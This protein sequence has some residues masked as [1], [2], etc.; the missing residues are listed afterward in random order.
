MRSADGVD[1]E[2]HTSNVEPDSG[3]KLLPE[4]FTLIF[5]HVGKRIHSECF[6]TDPYQCADG[7]E[8]THM[9]DCRHG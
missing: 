2:F 7:G 3:L 5:E 9:S 6:R 1:V 8:T 4:F